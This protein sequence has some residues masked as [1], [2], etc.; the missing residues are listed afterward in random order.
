MAKRIARLET[1]LR[2]AGYI[3]LLEILGGVLLAILLPYF[4]LARDWAIVFVWVA[5]LPAVWFL[6]QAARHQG[7]N[8]WLAGFVSIPPLIALVNF[9]SLWATAKLHGNEV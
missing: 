2:R 8:P 4:G 6:A 7:R 3:L 5:N 1:N 9:L